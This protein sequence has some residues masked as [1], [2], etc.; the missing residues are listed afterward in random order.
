MQF[1][2]RLKCH[3]KNTTQS[4]LLNLYY[5]ENI[6]NVIIFCSLILM[7]KI[8]IN[9]ERSYLFKILTLYI[10]IMITT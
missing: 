6:W 8:E 1:I 10:N 4:Q 3:T 7:F 2:L 5:I 9:I